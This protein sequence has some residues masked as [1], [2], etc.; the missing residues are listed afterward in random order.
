MI[1][2]VHNIDGTGPAASRS[3]MYAA[4]KEARTLPMEVKSF[5][6]FG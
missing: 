5:D 1:S 3:V 4:L 2:A 6:D